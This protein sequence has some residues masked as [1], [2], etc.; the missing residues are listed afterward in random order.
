MGPGKAKN[1]NMKKII[2]ILLAIIVLTSC[3]KEAIT[4]TSQDFLGQW[5]LVGNEGVILQVDED[6]VWHPYYGRTAY[7]GLSISDASITYVELGPNK[8]SW[9]I[10][11]GRLNPS[12]DTLTT[13]ITWCIIHKVNQD[14]DKYTPKQWVRIN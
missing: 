3:E 12:L 13:H 4:H 1:H 5:A 7:E 2:L 11:E 6:R 14:V 9:A 8:C 10:H